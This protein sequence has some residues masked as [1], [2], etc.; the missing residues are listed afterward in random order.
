MPHYTSFSAPPAARRKHCD[1]GMEQHFTEAAVMVA[2]A[3]HLLEHGAKSVEVHPD[4]EHGKRYDLKESLRIHGFAHVSTKG[5]TSYGGV[6]RRGEQTVEITLRPGLGD[7]VADMGDRTLVGECKGGVINSRH[8]GQTSR[9]RR[10]L[11]EA[12]GL[13]MARPPGDERH[14]AVVPATETAERVALR[15]LPRTR[16]VGIE[17][18]L[19]D[20]HGAVRFLSDE[21]PL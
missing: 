19:V 16:M 15:M 21:H 10:A 20:Q 14:V 5:T 6:Y 3:M 11:C 9:Q 17:I 1:G 4:G 12:V 2:F 7:V 18:A 8:A 13:L